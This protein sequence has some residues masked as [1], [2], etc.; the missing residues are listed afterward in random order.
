MLIPAYHLDSAL[1]QQ[2][3]WHF[4][5]ACS[6]G[7][8]VSSSERLPIY[9]SPVRETWVQ[10]AGCSTQAQPAQ[11]ASD[12]LTPKHR[13]WTL[14]SG[15]APRAAW[16]KAQFS[17]SGFLWGKSFCRIRFPSAWIQP[18]ILQKAPAVCRN[19]TGEPAQ[20]QRETKNK[21][22]LEC[23][24]CWNWRQQHFVRYTQAH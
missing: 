15:L 12:S 16:H 20:N 23:Y 2:Q 13:E 22:L 3:L 8:P 10:I 14:L 18:P 1:L 11:A 4:S 9:C 5:A 17:L 7:K 6:T 21:V 24:Y 19:S